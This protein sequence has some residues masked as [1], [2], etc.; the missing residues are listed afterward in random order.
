MHTRIRPFLVALAILG[1]ALSAQALDTRDKDLLLYFS[2]NKKADTVKDD[3]GHKNDG[4]IV[5]S[6]DWVKGKYGTALA[7]KEQGEVSAPH[8]PFDKR[9][10]TVAMWVYPDG[11]VVGRDRAEVQRTH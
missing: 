8:I 11:R 7:F 1:L 4:V 6:V 3:S 5:G 10:F 2:A 9:S